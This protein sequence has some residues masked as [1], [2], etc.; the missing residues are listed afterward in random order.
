MSLIRKLLDWFTGKNDKEQV[1]ELK[2]VLPE[3]PPPKLQIRTV[4]DVKALTQIRTFREVRAFCEEVRKTLTIYKKSWEEKGDALWIH[5]KAIDDLYVE[6]G[7]LSDKI[8]R[9]IESQK[10]EG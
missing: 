9:L 8:D 1:K 4:Q 2:E 7:N 10:G 5:K 6:M 3:D